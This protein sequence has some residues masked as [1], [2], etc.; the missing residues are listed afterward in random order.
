[1]SQAHDSHFSFRPLRRDMQ[2]L[3]G[4]VWALPRF[5]QART[6]PPPRH[7]ELPLLLHYDYYFTTFCCYY[8]YYADGNDDEDD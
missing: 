1:M 2:H 6:A 7:Q 5:S 3:A 8:Y 4:E